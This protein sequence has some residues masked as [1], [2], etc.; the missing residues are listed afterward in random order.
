MSNVESRC[1]D[2]FPEW[3]RSLADDALALAAIVENAEEPEARRRKAASALNY[4]FKSLD[5]IPDGIEDLGFLDD[6]FVFRVAA[7]ATPADGSDVLSRLASDT[8]LLREFLGADYARLERF[9]EG[10]ESG[11]ARGRSVA[12]IVTEAPARNAL[13][14]DVKGWAGGYAVPAFGRDTKNLV[15]L[16]SF[17]GAKLPA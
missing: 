2:A 7:A 17:L 10:L 6:A 3:L 5:L 14:S 4:L 8:A 11:S 15:K 13:V 1:L 9:V 16:K 12:Q